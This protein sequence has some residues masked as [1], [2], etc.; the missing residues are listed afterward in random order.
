MRRIGVLTSLE[1]GD[2][3]AQA[4]IGAFHQGL[5][6]LGWNVGRNLQIDYRWGGGNAARYP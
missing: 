4:R 6:Q 1:A 2:S 5:G 3:Q